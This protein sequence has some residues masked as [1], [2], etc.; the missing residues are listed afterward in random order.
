MGTTVTEWATTPVVPAGGRAEERLSVPWR[1]VVPIAVVVAYADGFW[2]IAMRGAVGSVERVD[3]PFRTWLW[4]STLLLPVYALAVLAALAVALR[5]FGPDPRR[6][7]GGAA[8]TLLAVVAATTLVGVAVLSVS[9]AYDYRLQLAEVAAQNAAGHGCGVGCLTAREQATLA[10]QLRAVGLGG[11]LLLVSNAVLVVLDVAFRGGRLAVAVRRQPRVAHEGDTLQ[12]P[13]GVCGLLVACLVGAA[14]IHAAVAPGYLAEWP[15]AGLFFVILALADLC[16]AALV[17]SR[18]RTRA[19]RAAA[20]LSAATVLVWLDSRTDGLSFGP[21]AGV[22]VPVG[23]A[24]GA[25]TVLEVATLLTALAA[26]TALRTGRR[27]RPPRRSDHGSRLALVGLVAV[28][29]VGLGGALGIFGEPGHG[30]SLSPGQAA[31]HSTGHTP[32]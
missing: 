32:G 12:P 11:L 9:S 27:S 24:D 21:G 20:L 31:E 1:T 17:L 7:R 19:L 18:F 30:I 25:A 28:S 10:L 26:L 3:A 16:V 13:P 15:T 22:A 5:R 23:V 6:V 8:A 4:E 14:A 2:V 29:C